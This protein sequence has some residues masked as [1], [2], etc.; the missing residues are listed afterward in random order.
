MPRSEATQGLFW[1]GPRDFEP[2]SDNEDIRTGTLS[3]KFCTTTA[4]G[5][6]T[7]TYDLTCNSPD[8]RRI[9]SARFEPG[10]LRL[11][12]RHLTSRPSLP[13]KLRKRYILKKNVEAN[14]PE[15]VCI[16][17]YSLAKDIDDG[18]LQILLN[19]G[20]VSDMG[21]K[22]SISIDDD[23]LTEVPIKNVNVI[24]QKHTN[25]DS[26]DDDECNMNENISDKE[27][28]SIKSYGCFLDTVPEL[29]KFATSQGD[30]EMLEILKNTR[31]LT[32]RRIIHKKICTENNAGLF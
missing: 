3:P 18:N 22:E 31:I 10:I 13:Q 6:L 1:G 11:K 23:I 19:M 30:A 17:N 24:I 14:L 12:G 25:K 5:R 16:E 27:Q 32:K 7:P 15:T 26:S 9:F 20:Q 21:A 29:E 8:T 2:W 4:G 28:L